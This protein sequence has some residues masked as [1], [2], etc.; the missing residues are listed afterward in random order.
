MVL[1]FGF[2]GRKFLDAASRRVMRTSPGFQHKKKEGGEGSG[3]EQREQ[4]S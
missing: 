1:Q 2:L 3:P 4:L